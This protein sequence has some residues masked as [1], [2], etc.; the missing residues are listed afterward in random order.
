MTR[1]LAEWP[2]EHGQTKKVGPS[3][4]CRGNAVPLAAE[5][6]YEF[7]ELG[8]YLGNIGLVLLIHLTHFAKNVGDP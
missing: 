2:F 8:A 6:K 3:D 5:S 4:G 1:K 7:Q